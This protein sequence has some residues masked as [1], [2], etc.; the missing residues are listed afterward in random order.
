MKKIVA[1]MLAAMFLVSSFALAADDPFSQA[2]LNHQARKQGEVLKKTLPRAVIGAGIGGAIGYG[3]SRMVGASVP[4]AKGGTAIGAALG[5]I[6]A[7]LWDRKA[8]RNNDAAD[9]KQAAMLQ[10]R[11]GQNDLTQLESEYEAKFAAQQ[12][13]FNARFSDLEKRFTERAAV[14]TTRNGDNVVVNAGVGAIQPPVAMVG[15]ENCLPADKFKRT[16]VFDEYVGVWREVR[17]REK[18]SVS[19]N[20]PNQAPPVRTWAKTPEGGEGW[21]RLVEGDG[22]IQVSVGWWRIQ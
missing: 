3:V 8:N 13:S 4:M 18:R 17:S 11:G 22:L 19:T 20:N 6:G 12:T 7:L 14:S 16:Q 21:I 1:V 15:V 9:G 10:D 2:V 5:G